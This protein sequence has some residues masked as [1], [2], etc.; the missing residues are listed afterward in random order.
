MKHLAISAAAMLLIVMAARP[1]PAQRQQHLMNTIK[2]Y[3]AKLAKEKDP[4]ERLRLA[5]EIERARHEIGPRDATGVRNRC[6]AMWHDAAIDAL[7]TEMKRYAGRAKTATGPGIALD[8]RGYV[9]RMAMVCLMRGWASGGTLPRYQYDAY[10][11]YLYNNIGLLDGL[12]DAVAAALAKETSP[13]PP[14]P[15]RDAFVAACA[16]AR[17][18]IAKMGDALEKFAAEAKRPPERKAQEEAFGEFHRALEGVYEAEGLLKDAPK[19]AAE[20]APAPSAAAGVTLDDKTRLEKV[21]AVAAAL[22]QDAGWQPS[23]TALE[24][25]AA[26]AETGLQVQRARADALELLETL[27]RTADFIQELL[28][29]RSAYPEYVTNVQDSLKVSFEE[30]GTKGYR[31]SAY[32]HLRRTCEGGI[33]RKALDASPLSDEAARGMLQVVR[34]DYHVFGYPAGYQNYN[35]FRNG[36]DAVLAI[37]P[38]AGQWSAKDA[39]PQ[40]AALHKIAYEEFL[41]KAEAAGKTTPE[42]T[43]ALKDAYAA[44]GVAAKDLDRI[45][46]A[47][48]AIKAVAQYV[49][50]R[51]APMYADFLKTA[52]GL[53]GN[54]AIS[55]MGDRQRLDL[56]LP[57]F[58]ELADLQLPAAEHQ[59]T[60]TALTGGTYQQALAVLNKQ[61][62]QGLQ[63][64]AKGDSRSLD[65][66]LDAQL[67]FKLL[68][69]RCVAEAAGL[70]K[71][72]VANMDA[73]SVPDKNW[74]RFVGALDQN[75]RRMMTQ[76]C[77]PRAVG[78]L[79]YQPIGQWDWTYCNVAAAQR[80]TAQTRR[81]GQSDLDFL[82][83][84]LAEVAAPS[85]SEQM[86]FAWIV[87]YQATEAATALAAGY[88]NTAG[89][90]LADLRM[91]R[92]EMRF[93]KEFTSAVLDPGK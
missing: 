59:R 93:P 46:Q 85:P 30:L 45:V 70:A 91:T 27:A 5:D 14:G 13:G 86:Q 92:T 43:A 49:P 9:R 28:K 50:A 80:L 53:I 18:A 61:V 10:G 72:D 25:F 88:P 58:Q 34:L 40:M 90:H 2:T 16:Q 7:E 37:L 52:D 17:D 44:A 63:T 41:L 65:A 38:K 76:Y 3:E 32:S 8:A 64:A 75:L 36:F 31:Q 87:G 83:R 68:R 84:N 26:V 48:R 79:Q 66:A 11:T 39:Q 22:G 81:A 82:M 35:S 74:A 42:N 60:A 29:S 67:L 77:G 12:F 33:E 55:R 54:T 15:E 21:R 78:S 47:D 20:G 23:R 56:F 57:P 6:Q 71:V 73:F 69:H 51:A 62:V 4:A 24:K 1:A 89:M 19:K